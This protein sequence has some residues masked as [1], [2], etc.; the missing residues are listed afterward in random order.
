MN[1][2]SRLRHPTDGQPV[3]SPSSPTRRRGP[4]SPERRLTASELAVESSLEALTTALSAWTDGHEPSGPLSKSVAGAD[5]VERAVAVRVAIAAKQVRQWYVEVSAWEW[6]VVSK[7]SSSTGFE[8]PTVEERARKRRRVAKD[9]HEGVILSPRPFPDFVWDD[10][11]E[12]WGGC[13]ARLAKLCQE[14]IDVI[15]NAIDDLEMRD[16]ESSVLDAYNPSRLRPT[17]KSKDGRAGIIEAASNAGLDDMTAVMTATLLQAL[18][19]LAQLV[20][21]LDTW[22]A[23]LDVL[24]IVSPFLEQIQDTQIALEFGYRAIAPRVTL[25]E[26]SPRDATSSLGID[27]KDLA[28]STESSAEV[29]IRRTNTESEV[30]ISGSN[31][32]RSG[33]AAM[34]AT[35]ARKVASA[36]RRL[37]RMLDILE[38]RDDTLPKDW[39]DEM[40]M[41]ERNYAHWVFEAESVVLRNKIKP[42]RRFPHALAEET[43]GSASARMENRRKAPDPSLLIELA[44]TE[45]AVQVSIADAGTKPDAERSTSVTGDL[46]ALS[47]AGSARMRGSISSPV[48]GEVQPDHRMHGLTESAEIPRVQAASTTSTTL[49]ECDRNRIASPHPGPPQL[50]SQYAR[51]VDTSG[52][53]RENQAEYGRQSNSSHIYRMPVKQSWP[54]SLSGSKSA[55]SASR[56]IESNESQN[57]QF[58]RDSET[59]LRESEQGLD[60]MGD[61]FAA[62]RK[63]SVGQNASLKPTVPFQEISARISSTEHPSSHEALTFKPDERDD[64][65][66]V[67]DDRSSHVAPSV[68]SCPEG[69]NERPSAIFETDDESGED[70][71]RPATTPESTLEPAS[72]D[73]LAVRRLSNKTAG[74]S[75]TNA[76]E[77]TDTASRLKQRSGQLRL[78]RP[79]I[80]TPIKTEESTVGTVRDPLSASSFPSDVSS[81]DLRDALAAVSYRPV[82]MDSTLL[83]SIIPPRSGSSRPRISRHTTNHFGLLRRERASSEPIHPDNTHSRRGMAFQLRRSLSL[84]RRQQK[85]KW[86]H[87]QHPGSSAP[88]KPVESNPPSETASCSGS[89]PRSSPRGGGGW[90][91]SRAH[92]KQDEQPISPLFRAS[93]KKVAGDS[94]IATDG[95]SKSVK[96]EES[97]PS[98]R[99]GRVKPTEANLEEKISSIL[100]SIPAHI[101]LASTPESN[102]Q[103]GSRGQRSPQLTPKPRSGRN[104]RHSASYVLAPAEGS[105]SRSHPGD[106]KQDGKWYH[107]RRSDTDVP[108]RMFVPPVGP[109]TER[110]M[111]RVGGGWSELGEYLRDYALHHSRRSGSAAGGLV[112]VTRL[113][114]DTLSSSARSQHDLEAPIPGGDGSRHKGTSRP[115]SALARPRPSPPSSYFSHS[116]PIR[117]TRAPSELPVTPATTHDPDATGATASNVAMP[118]IPARHSPSPSPSPS[119]PASPVTGTAAPLHISKQRHGSLGSSTDARRRVSRRTEPL[120]AEKQAWVDDM[121]GKVRRG[122]SANYIHSAG[123]ATPT[124]STNK[125]GRRTSTPYGVNDSSG[126]TPPGL[127]FGELGTVNRTRRLFRKD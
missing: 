58:F 4:S 113:P 87:Q 77:A 12:Y 11:E 39:V 122:A 56:S 86:I 43:V 5:S 46:G 83:T 103:P 20:E 116:L 48:A 6:P 105:S 81:P 93:K 66:P 65:P 95:P 59:P 126:I 111:V 94:P 112:E 41:L 98:S 96:Q 18:P 115:S 29:C 64:K 69:A 36:G 24:R 92:L 40:E 25:Q 70:S 62:A 32:T 55:S 31:L 53:C 85:I 97:A 17:S 37:D 102:P 23:R 114:S 118:S 44:V 90:K 1:P 89:G 63:R 30:L 80:P 88:F 73:T 49:R 124:N 47:D 15:R 57:N 2:P 104:T 51:D 117:K 33:L 52:T 19:C 100:D 68:L 78:E 35:L 127:A 50:E 72:Q 10:K 120:S 123:P 22:S 79:D 54:A 84:P 71:Q 42:E 91:S 67:A 13:P 9:E 21:A 26:G 121:I 107:L 109:N 14:R 76:E 3:R 38:G 7:T 106:K 27:S 75:A 8:L 61:C 16:L 101:R 34:Q 125:V 82:Y 108:I 74:S 99:T 45:G 110:V 60:L 119:S 28:S